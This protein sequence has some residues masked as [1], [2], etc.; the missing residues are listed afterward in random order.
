MRKNDWKFIINGLMFVD[1]CSI[2]VIGLIMAF[3]IPPGKS[4][5]VSKYFLGL[6]RHQWGDLHLYLSLA[7][8]LFLVVHLWFNWT[9][10]QN[11]TRSYFGERWKKAL[12][13]LCGAW[14]GVLMVGWIL[15]KL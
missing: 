3:V 15:M 1:I 11:S 9:W 6:H 2:A 8:L 4:P 7:L 13:I 5:D 12:L 10:I 14:F